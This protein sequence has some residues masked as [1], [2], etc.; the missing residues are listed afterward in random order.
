MK[1]NIG[2]IM[3]GFSTERHIS[4]ESG[5]NV[6]EKLASSNQYNPIPIFLTGDPKNLR[7]FVLPINVL[8]KDNADD[9]HTLLLSKQECLEK[10]DPLFQIRKKALNITEKYGEQLPLLREILIDQLPEIVDFVFIA[11]HGHPG[12]DGTLQSILNRIGIPYNGSDVQTSK[13]AMN[14]HMTNK[15]L[16]ETGIYVAKQ[17]LIKKQEWE[18]DNS[19]ILKKIL[20]AITYPLIAKPVDEGCSSGV[21]KIKDEEALL[22]Y[23]T[24][25]FSQFSKLHKPEFI[26][27]ELIHKKDAHHFLEISCGLLTQYKQDGEL[28]YEIFPPSETLAGGE[29]LSLEEKFLAGEGQNITPARF[30]PNK[31]ISSAILEKV[32]QDIKK[33]ATILGIE[34]YARIDAFVKI[35][36][37]KSVK[38]YIIEP[39]TL[40]G[41]TPA[42]CIF[43]QCILHGYTPLD[44]I[45]KIIGF[46]YNK[47]N[48]NKI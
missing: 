26:V 47:F 48:R 41:L 25:I 12:E 16:H 19:V 23:A 18:D 2:V 15:V 1:K 17:I 9:I 30:D 46:G 39:N 10:N 28:E 22:Q 5:R 37:D 13:L 44:F 7:F 45:H 6:Y 42:T 14:K 31:D 38:T 4:V 27:E 11:L 32:Q 8:L 20:A 24:D 35:Y 3:G 29:V 43:H 21:V 40:P 34:G 33:A 36:P